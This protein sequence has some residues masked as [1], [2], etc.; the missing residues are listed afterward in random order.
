MMIKKKSSKLLSLFCM[1]MLL[2]IIIIA[3]PALAVS[4]P[5]FSNW[6]WTSDTNASCIAVGDAN[7]DNQTDVVIGGYFNTGNGWSSQL[8]VLNSSSY[9]IENFGYWDWGPD[10]Q[11]SSVAIGDVNADDK[12]EIVTAGSYFNGSVWNS[13]VAVQNCSSTSTA[14]TTLNINAWIVG[15]GS[16]VSSVAIGDVNSDG[17]NE[18]VTAGSSF[19]GTTW[20][21]LVDVL[22]CST[23]TTA[24]NMQSS[25]SWLW[26]TKSQLSSVAIGDVYGDGKKE[27]VTGGSFNDSLRM[28]T[29]LHVLNW[30]NPASSSLSVLNS[31]YWYWTSDTYINS[32]TLANIT[33]TAGLTI[34]TAGS[35]FDGSRINAQ[36]H[37]LNCTS[38]SPNFVVQQSTYWVWTGNTVVNCV[39]VGN[40][41]GNPTLDIVTGG[42]Y[43]DGARSVAQFMDINSAN[44]AQRVVTSWFTSSDTN[45]YGVAIGN[46]LL[47][48]R[49]LA[50][51]SYFDNT[52]SVAQLTVWA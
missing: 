13:L 5:A 4:S 50:A 51:G 17:K 1:L 44:M 27:I 3:K 48:N 19:N 29:M 28:N 45:I 41:T 25:G 34:V 43:F 11:I 22:N 33:G 49:V 8:H 24:L 36:V 7:N 47:G 6:Y 16:Q 52:R 21:A 2:S 39:T 40:F 18:I 32:L 30:T 9:A 15:V 38:T 26:G 23:T 10:S 14:L 35:F 37:E 20:S 46:T 31:G 42:S 12:N